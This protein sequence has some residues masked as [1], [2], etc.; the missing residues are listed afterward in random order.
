MDS[1][2]F[3]SNLKIIHKGKTDFGEHPF[4]PTFIVHFFKKTK[5]GVEC[6]NDRKIYS[7][8]IK[9]QMSEIVT[10]C[11]VHDNWH[12]AYYTNADQTTTQRI[13]LSTLSV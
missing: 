8:V 2:E 10:V 11:L 12:H 4:L 6:C 13:L 7:L 1:T 9:S 5:E 3:K